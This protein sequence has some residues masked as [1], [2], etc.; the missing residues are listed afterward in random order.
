MGPL[1]I[2]HDGVAGTHL[3][4]ELSQQNVPQETP[5]PHELNIEAVSRI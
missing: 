5:T 1:I 2:S 3:P 4:G